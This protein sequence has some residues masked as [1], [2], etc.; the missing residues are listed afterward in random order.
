M[1]EEEGRARVKLQGELRNV[2]TELEHARDLLEDEQEGKAELQ[3]QVAKA[4]SE[5]AS[6]RQKFENGEGGIK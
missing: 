1:L 5:A 3:R 2:Q 6:W 4:T